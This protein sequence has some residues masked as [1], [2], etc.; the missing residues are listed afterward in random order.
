VI[1]FGAFEWQQFAPWV[2]AAGSVANGNGIP[3]MATVS[4]SE[5]WMSTSALP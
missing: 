5:I 4:T 2:K 1:S 3:S